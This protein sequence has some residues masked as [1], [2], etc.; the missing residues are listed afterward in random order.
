MKLPSVQITGNWCHGTASG[1]RIVNEVNLRCL[2]E[3][4]KTA[5]IYVNTHMLKRSSVVICF[6]TSSPAGKKKPTLFPSCK[7]HRQLVRRGRRQL[8][9]LHNLLRRLFLTIRMQSESAS[10]PAALWRNAR[11]FSN[12][13]AAAAEH[14]ASKPSRV[15]VCHS[16]HHVCLSPHP[17]HS[18]SPSSPVSHQ[19][20][21]SSLHLPL[22]LPR[23]S[24]SLSTYL[25]FYLLA[26]FGVP[27]LISLFSSPCWVDTEL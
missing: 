10:L 20:W 15:T 19:G 9:C 8:A 13:I 6:Q 21:I 5:A 27:L 11:L 22:L 2:R 1:C 12:R 18:H 4:A 25:S 16:P 3:L 23:L 26:D 17:P 14:P 7:N 24:P